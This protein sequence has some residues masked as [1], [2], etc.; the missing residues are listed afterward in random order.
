MLTPNDVAKVFDTVLSIPGMNEPVKM[1]MRLSRKNILLLHAVIKR[2]LSIKE[3]HT[4]SYF[5]EGIPGV[6]LEELEAFAESC[7]EKAGLTQLS[8]KLKS[9]HQTKL[10][11]LE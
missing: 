5:L 2:G 7:L 4:A 11:K 9:L 6:A 1:D 10:P 8:D 3:P